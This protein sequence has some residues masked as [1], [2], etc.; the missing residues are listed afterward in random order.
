MSYSIQLTVFIEMSEKSLSSS[1]HKILK[2]V[3]FLIF[4]SSFEISTRILE[5]KSCPTGSVL[6]WLS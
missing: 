6:F 1:K 5:D 2:V 3:L 4:N